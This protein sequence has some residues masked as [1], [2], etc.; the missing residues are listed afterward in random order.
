VRRRIAAKPASGL[1]AQDPSLLL[2]GAPLSPPR[3][4]ACLRDMDYFLR[5]ASYAL[6]S[7]TPPIL[8]GSGLNGPRRHL[9]AV[10]AP[11]QHGASISLPRRMWSTSGLAGE[12]SRLPIVA[13]ILPLTKAR[14]LPWSTFRA[15]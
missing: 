5:Y 8:D 1:F 13:R 4:Y 10:C 3:L 6:V 15:R 7:G 11:A 2:P 14:G 9:K 12:A